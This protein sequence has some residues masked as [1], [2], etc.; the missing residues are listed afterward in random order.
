MNQQYMVNKINTIIC[1]AFCGT[2]KTHI[3]QQT[4]I[5]SIEV[6]Y[7]KYKDKG[8]HKEY[9]EDIKKHLGKLDYIFIS[10]D[11]DGL[12]LLYKE[13]FHITLVYPEN[14]LRNEYLDRYINR[15]SPHDFIGAF[16]KYWDIWLNELKDQKECKHIVLKKGEYLKD[17][18]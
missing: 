12:K 11:P 13:G 1:A 4:D 14:E 18:I 9:I 15:D 6:E 8:L 17:V 5:K 3:C 2:G 16:M 7:Y 10:T